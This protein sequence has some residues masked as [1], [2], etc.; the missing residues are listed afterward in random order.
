[1][2][3]LLGSTQVA[4]DQEIWP[5]GLQAYQQFMNRLD[6]TGNPDLRS[7]FQESNIA[8]LMDDLIAR[9]NVMNADGLRALGSTA[10]LQVQPMRR[11][12][13]LGNRLV[14]PQSPPLAAFLLALK[15]FTEAFQYSS[16]GSRL[17]HVAR[18]AIVSYGLY[19]LAG[20]DPATTR[21]GNLVIARGNLA[22]ELDCL[23]NCGCSSDDVRCQVLLDKVLYDLDRAIDAMSLGVDPDGKGDA[24]MRAFAYGLLI[25]TL[26]LPNVVDSTLSNLATKAQNEKNQKLAQQLQNLRTRF[27]FGKFGG[28]R[29]SDCLFSAPATFRNQ[30]LGAALI[31]TV[32]ALLPDTAW[33][34]GLPGNL[35]A[36]PAGFDGTILQELCMQ[37]DAEGQWKNLLQTMAASCYNTTRLVD[38]TTTLVEATRAAHVLDSCGA[39]DVTLPATIET[40]LAGFVF[41]ERS[42]G[43]R[44]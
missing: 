33:A 25:E 1:L 19:G 2:R 36:V 14:D 41:K 37:E 21:L 27:D 26:L 23:L 31:A 39:V 10:V 35:T 18:P 12:I 34:A 38:D 15:L 40:S 17:I 42:E 3:N 24:E 30:T 20:P 28:V 13:Q 9:V 44:E 29:Q 7:L 32:R 16:S 43:G 8:R 6:S 5:R 4:Y 11:L 22:I